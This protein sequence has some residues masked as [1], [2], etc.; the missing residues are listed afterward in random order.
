MLHFLEKR[1]IIEK[2]ALLDEGLEK[3]SFFSKKKED[4]S[5]SFEGLSNKERKKLEK[6]L[7]QEKDDKEFEDMVIM[8]EF[9]L[10]DDE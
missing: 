8:A 4:N 6:K 2:T 1:K 7:K 3:M 10:D 5:N 9:F